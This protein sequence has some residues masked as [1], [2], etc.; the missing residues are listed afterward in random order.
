MT[1]YSTVAGTAVAE[2]VKVAREEELN[3]TEVEVDDDDDDDEEE[4]EEVVVENKANEFDDDVVVDD[5]LD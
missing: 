4:E 3:G 2:V 1:A 5:D